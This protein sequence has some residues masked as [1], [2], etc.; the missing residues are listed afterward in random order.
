MQVLTNAENGSAKPALDDPIT[1]LSTVVDELTA[2]ISGANEV[3]E[4]QSS[5]SA[6]MQTISGGPVVPKMAMKKFVN[7]PKKIWCSMPNIQLELDENNTTKSKCI[8]MIQVLINAENGS[9]KPALDDPITDLSTVVDELTAVISA[10]DGSV[11]PALDPITDLGTVADELT[12]TAVEKGLCCR[13]LWKRT[14][15]FVHR[16]CCCA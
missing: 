14:K 16:M 13:S 15:K 8:P 1:D 7:P 5:T 10:E 6:P 11:K 4:I 2:M 9:V 12:V 3:L